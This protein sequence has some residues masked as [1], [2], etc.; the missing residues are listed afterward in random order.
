MLLCYTIDK[1]GVSKGIPEGAFDCIL[2][3]T[4]GPVMAAE[5][6]LIPAV[7]GLS[8]GLNDAQLCLAFARKTDPNGRKPEH[9]ALVSVNP[10]CW[11]PASG[12]CSAVLL[13]PCGNGLNALMYL[14]DDG[15]ILLRATTP[16]KPKVLSVPPSGHV[17]V[18]ASMDQ[19]TLSLLSLGFTVEA[20]FGAPEPV[21]PKAL[22]K[23]RRA[24]SR[25]P[26]REAGTP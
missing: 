15:S 9:G 14:P 4:P 1:G 6:K 25:K 10:L 17:P 11:V 2:A 20:L 23:A 12:K 5:L 16:G 26:A 18:M 8:G 19:A 24:A 3:D 7:E 21:S 22:P 13:D